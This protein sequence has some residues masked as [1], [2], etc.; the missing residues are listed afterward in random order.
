[1]KERERK[2]QKREMAKGEEEAYVRRKNARKRKRQ[3]LDIDGEEAN[4]LYSFAYNKSKAEKKIA[5]YCTNEKDHAII[6]FAQHILCIHDA[7]AHNLCILLFELLS[8]STVSSLSLFR[9]FAL[10]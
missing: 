10:E 4:L 7:S 2:K 8:P 5:S 3:K 9:I 1:M 6:N